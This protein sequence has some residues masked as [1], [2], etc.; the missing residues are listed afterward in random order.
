MLAHCQHAPQIR[1]LL[2]LLELLAVAVA[3]LS[4]VLCALCS[5]LCAYCAR[6]ANPGSKCVSQV[7]VASACCKQAR[8]LYLVTGNL[9]SLNT[10][11]ITAS[12]KV[13]LETAVETD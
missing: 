9:E 7:R 2:A 4:A 1:F 3:L 8:Y 10:F 6:V 13:T 11:G 5:V 12:L